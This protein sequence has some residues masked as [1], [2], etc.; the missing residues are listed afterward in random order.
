MEY[1]GYLPLI[2]HVEWCNYEGSWKA[3]WSVEEPTD[4]LR[5]QY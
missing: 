4:I 2:N 5:V 3:E 1:S